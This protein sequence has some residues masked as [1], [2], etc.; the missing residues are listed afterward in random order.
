MASYKVLDYT[1]LH[2]FE[3][4]GLHVIQSK[5]VVNLI[6]DDNLLYTI[7]IYPGAMCDGLSIPT[8]LRWFLPK[9]DKDNDLYNIAGIIHDGLYA[10]ELLTKDT[11]DDIFR[12][13]LRDAGI[14]RFKA[15]TAEW[16]VQTFAK[17]HY[18]RKHDEYNM[19]AYV[20]VK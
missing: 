16:C 4:N 14:S 2:S 5:L 13:I 20:S 10:S 8:G 19:A 17:C 1:P 18:G 11:A 6:R 9:W 7:T 15:S 3:M 12:S